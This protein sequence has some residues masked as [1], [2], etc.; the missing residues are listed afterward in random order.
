MQRV[1]RNVPWSVTQRDR[2]WRG[3]GGR[4]GCTGGA[5]RGRDGSVAPLPNP[6]A[7]YSQKCPETGQSTRAKEKRQQRRFPPDCDIFITLGA[8]GRK[9]LAKPTQR[10]HRDHTKPSQSPPRADATGPGPRAPDSAQPLRV[11]REG[12]AS[13]LSVHCATRKALR[14]NKLRGSECEPKRN[15]V[16]SRNSA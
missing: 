12:F 3:R 1:C 9:A 15:F 8:R 2:G 13:A 10:P 7:G 14:H 6:L 16:V 4:W 11:P 5:L